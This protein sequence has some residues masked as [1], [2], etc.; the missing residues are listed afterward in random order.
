[1]PVILKTDAEAAWLAPDASPGE[2]LDLL[3]PLDG[4]ALDV[5]EVGDAVNDVRRDGPELLEPPLKL[6]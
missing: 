2:L 4:A 3:R 1:M 5:R 6:L